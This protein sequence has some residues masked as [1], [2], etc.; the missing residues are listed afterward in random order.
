MIGLI[1]V[2][3]DDGG[4]WGI[5]G[6]VELKVFYCV[7]IIVSDVECRDGGCFCVLGF[8][9]ECFIECFCCCWGIRGG[10]VVFDIFF[11]LWVGELLFF[12]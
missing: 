12:V 9:G 11:L 3:V 2:E 5:S 1:G 6:G 4:E 7:V 8:K 10:F